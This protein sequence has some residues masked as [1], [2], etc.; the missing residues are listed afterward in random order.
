MANSPYFSGGRNEVTARIEIRAI[1]V[2][3]SRP[4]L[5]INNSFLTFKVFNYRIYDSL[6]EER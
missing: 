4:E 2:E 1:N 3:I 5:I 6:R